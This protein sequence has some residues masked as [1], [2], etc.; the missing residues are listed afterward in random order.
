[1]S[2]FESF[3]RLVLSVVF[4][5]VALMALAIAYVMYSFAMQDY[6][7]KLDMF[8]KYDEL[9]PQ[10]VHGGVLLRQE[11]Q[12]DPNRGSK[13][14]CASSIYSISNNNIQPIELVAKA[15]RDRALSS[16]RWHTTPEEKNWRWPA[17]VP[18]FGCAD[19]ADRDAVD[20][21]LRSD[22]ALYYLDRGRLGFGNWDTGAMMLYDYLVVIDGKGRR[23]YLSFI[24]VERGG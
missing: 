9:L 8:E 12:D 14:W 7:L 24:A 17:R 15:R 10:R 5:A 2:A 13:R 19:G 16:N 22:G 23:V 3:V 1:M 20:A 4:G 6:W 21:L 11:R 18:Q